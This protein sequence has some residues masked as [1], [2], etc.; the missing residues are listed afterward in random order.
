MGNM[1]SWALL[2]NRCNLLPVLTLPSKSLRALFWKLDPPFLWN[3]LIN[4]GQ[5]ENPSKI[6]TI[7]LPPLPSH[8]A[9]ITQNQNYRKTPST[10]CQPRPRPLTRRTNR[11]TTKTTVL[12]PK[13]N[14]ST[15][16]QLHVSRLL[17]KFFTIQTTNIT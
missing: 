13:R 15:M 7:P 6:N 17:L 8:S 14:Q 5:D 10:S 4:V 16:T 9:F 1:K 12:A 2:F 3:I 11:P